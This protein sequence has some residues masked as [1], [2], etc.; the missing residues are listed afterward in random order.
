M[1]YKHRLNPQ[2]AKPRPRYQAYFP[3]LSVSLP[4][5]MK[6]LNESFM[7]SSVSGNT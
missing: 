6:E 5:S 1:E 3:N 2:V 7:N 4:G